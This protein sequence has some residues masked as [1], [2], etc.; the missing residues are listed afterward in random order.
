MLEKPDL[1]DQLI[2]TRLAEACGLQ[3]RQ[4]TFLPLGLDVNTAVY[5]AD[6]LDGTAY[7]LKLRKGD[8]AAASVTVPQYLAAHGIQQVMAPLETRQ[9]CASLRAG[10]D[11]YKMI[12]YPFIDG[13]NGYEAALSDQQWLD[14]GA[15]LRGIHTSHLPPELAGFI[16][17]EAYSPYWRSLV[18]AFQAQVE[19]T[20]YPDPTAAGL[21]EFMKA[22]RAEISHLAARAE[23]LAAA[24]Q[25]RSSQMVL[26]HGDIHAGNLLLGADGA[27]FLVDWD[28][29]IFAPK[30]RDL[31]LVGGSPTW[32]T[33]QGEALFYQG[34]FSNLGYRV[35]GQVEVDAMALAYFRYER[36]I[37]DIAEF[38]KQLLETAEGGQDREQSLRYFTGQ[39]LPGHE[40]DLACR[41]DRIIL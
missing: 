36:I 4:L 7:F 40:V 16:P 28:T 9:L 12:L 38:C 27:L 1:Q 14:F 37:T 8:F 3:V 26:C 34:Y 29:L 33:A 32:S 35:D 30:E 24:L 17:R 10:C 2:V 11:V 25:A 13:Q 15:A 39:F 20:I 23:V 22:R 6:A 18:R 41:A 19:G 31:A 5:R 21:A